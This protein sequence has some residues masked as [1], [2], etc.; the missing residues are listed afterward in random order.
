MKLHS[1]STLKLNER[2]KKLKQDR[3]TYRHG[4]TEFVR[5]MKT[6]AEEGVNKTFFTVYIKNA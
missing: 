6:R 2:N 3:H 4:D 5:W 1:R